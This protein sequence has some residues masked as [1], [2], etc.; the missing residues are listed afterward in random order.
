M[1]TERGCSVCRSKTAICWLT[2]LSRISKSSLFSAP[3]NSPAGFLT[4]AST[5]TRFTLTRICAPKAAASASAALTALS[6]GSIAV[7]LSFHPD[8]AVREVLLFPDGH[9]TLQPVDPL[10]AG[11]PDQ[12]AP[13]PVHEGDPVDGVARRNF[14]ADASQQLE[15]HRLVTVVIQVVRLAALGVVPDHAFERDHRAILSPQQAVGDLARDDGMP[16]QRE[17]VPVFRNLA[18]RAAS[19]ADGRQKGDLVAVGDRCGRPG[20]FLVARQQNAAG[21]LPYARKLATVVVEDV[22]QS[23]AIFQVELVFRPAHD[24]LEHPEK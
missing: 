23:G 17:E 19:A 10:H 15:G 22:A 4:V 12:Y 18:R 13:E 3:T 21:H 6:Q 2:P 24:V 1:A 11:L 14:A 8:L 16:R 20:E 9:H 7:P 5:R